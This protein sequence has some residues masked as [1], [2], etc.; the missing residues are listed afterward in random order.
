[1]ADASVVIATNLDDKKAL[2]DLDKLTQKV[3]EARKKLEEKQGKQS[4]IEQSLRN[5]EKAL[6]DFKAGADEIDEET[7]AKLQKKLEAV[8]AALSKAGAPLDTI[9]QRAKEAEFSVQELQEAYDSLV[10][11]NKAAPAKDTEAW[12]AGKYNDLEEEITDTKK[13]LDDAAAEAERLR[14]AAATIENAQKAYND[15][16]A[17]YNKAKQKELT[18]EVERQQQAYNKITEDVKK[19][20]AAL[21]EAETDAG[22]LATKIKEAADQTKGWRGIVKELDK[23]FEKLGARLKKLALNAAIFTVAASGFRKLKDYLWDVIL[24]NEEASA[25][26]ADLKGALLTLAQPSV[27]IVVPAF[28]GLVKILTA[29]INRILQLVSLITGKSVSASAAAAAALNKQTKALNSTGKAAKKASQ[30]LASF[31]ELNVMSSNDDSSSGSSG[32]DVGSITPDFGFMDGIDDTFQKIADWVLIIGTG[33]LTWKVLKDLPWDKI[34]SFFNGTKGFDLAKKFLGI[35]FVIAGLKGIS[36]AIK[37]IE[38][39]GANLEN[40]LKLIASIVAT[41]LGFSLLTGSVIPMVIAGIAAVVV[42]VLALTG[43]LEEFIHNLKENIL[44]GLID[45]LTGVFTG[46]WEKAWNGVKKIFAGIWNSIVMIVESA[47]NIIIKVINWVI[48]QINK[49][50]FTVPDWVPGL[51]GKYFGP[52]IPPIPEAHLTRIPAL[53][54]GAVIPPNREF[55]AVLGDQKSGTNIETPLDTM[56]GAFRQALAQDGYGGNAEMLDVMVSL[57]TYVRSIADSS[58]RTAQKDFTL[59]KP[60]SAAG[61]WVSQSME[62]Y[63]AVRG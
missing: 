51:G 20:A 44:G 59:G 11:K 48:A 25:A 40:V 38:E 19:Q 46:D 42:G 23:R 12:F 21:D 27:D 43:N 39:N 7:S 45:F 34:S 53:A 32:S 16:Y 61:R 2:R 4:A 31:D 22:D 13:A 8:D 30:Q 28:T 36:D 15:A 29:I 33:L 63:S 14:N 5:A 47:I 52:N 58:E 54:K 57:L 18:A 50:H 10:K 55:L 62:A 49:I 37:D 41:G 6:E 35:A 56:V 24:V 17:N 1:M 60:S 26:L 9:K 3:D